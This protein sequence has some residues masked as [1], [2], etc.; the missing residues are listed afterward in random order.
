MKHVRHTM[1]P[2]KLSSYLHQSSAG[3]FTALKIVHDE[4]WKIL[5]HSHDFWELL[6]IQR[7]TGVHVFRDR[8]YPIRPGSIF[9][10]AP[11]EVHSINGYDHLTQLNFMFHDEA[12]EFFRKEFE[13]MPNF[14]RL[15][16]LSFVE[17]DDGYNYLSE[18]FLPPLE[19]QV[20]R[21]AE[22]YELHPA[23]YKIS[24]C[25]ALWEALLLIL[26]NSRP[27][28]KSQSGEIC[29]LSEVIKYMTR[30]YRKKITLQTLASIANRSV[31][32]FYY[33]FRLQ[34]GQSP[35]SYLI[36]LRL[37][38]A[39]AL[40]DTTKMQVTTI[41]RATGFDDSNHF[42][43]LFKRKVGCS[44]REYRKKNHGFIYTFKD[45]A[46]QFVRQ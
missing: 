40:L 8:E 31:S 24:G 39:K 26:R 44:P 25:L 32:N 35:I 10:I 2:L 7:G 37:E 15:F 19:R 9:A 38:Q 6:V 20:Q 34:I 36:D 18:E 46:I 28:Q 41:S 30:N 21:I 23:G 29:N 33:N 16:S 5:P 14:Q 11:G 22:E 27:Y 13:A 1:E 43:A 17:K 45:D 42:S 12:I 3:S 4:T